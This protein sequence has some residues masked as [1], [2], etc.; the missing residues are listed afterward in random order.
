M[1]PVIPL[2]EDKIV[3]GDVEEGFSKSDVIV[4]GEFEVGGAFHWY[5]EPQSAYVHPREDGG[6]AVYAST[7]SA[8]MS[9]ERV[10]ALSHLSC[11]LTINGDR[12]LELLAFPSRKS[13]YK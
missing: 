2:F 3:K 8:G 6:I 11:C 5:M 12:L 7:Q 4:E 1:F 10:S 13:L 9:Q